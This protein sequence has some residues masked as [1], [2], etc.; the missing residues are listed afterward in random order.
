MAAIKNQMALLS[1]YQPSG[2]ALVLQSRSDGRK[3][4]PSEVAAE[5]ARAWAARDMGTL[6]RLHVSDVARW[7]RLLGGGAVDLEDVIHDVFLVAFRRLDDFEPQR[8]AFGT[9]LYGVTHKVVRA[10]LRKER[11][12]A[13]LL[14]VFPW[15]VATPSEEG[16]WMDSSRANQRDAEATL[17]VLLDRVAERYRTPLVLF[18]LEGLSCAEIADVTGTSTANVYVRIHRGRQKLAA[19]LARYRQEGTEFN[20]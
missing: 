18:E 11:W 9:W 4:P 15:W 6:Y 17:A 14:R 13:R 7:V 1:A 5:S 16:A 3:R 12:R 19:E 2:D 20:G 8:A 10:V